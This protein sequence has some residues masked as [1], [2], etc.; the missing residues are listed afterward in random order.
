MKYELSNG[1]NRVYQWDRNITIT[2]TEP[3]NVPQVHF[4]WGGEAAPF[5]VTDQQV[6]IPP[7]LMQLPKNIVFWAYTPDH[8]ID[9]ALIPLETR[10]KPADYVYTPTEIKTW[11]QLD[12]RIKALEEGGGISGVS[13]VNGQTGAVEITAKG[14]GAL[15]KD[16]LQDATNAALAQAKASGEFDGAQGPKGDTGAQ[17]PKG[18]TG[19]QGPQGETGPQGSAGPQGPTGPTGT[20]GAGLDVTGAAVG[21]IVKITAVDDNGVPTAWSPVDMPSGGSG[22]GETWELVAEITTTENVN[23]IRATFDACSAVYI[24]FRWGGVEDDLGDIAIYPNTG[25]TP[26]A[27][28]QRAAAAKVTSSTSQKYGVLCVRMDCRVGSYWYATSWQKARGDGSFGAIDASQTANLEIGLSGTAQYS[29]VSNYYMTT[30]GDT[31]AS[32]VKSITAYGAGM[33]IGTTLKVWG[34]KK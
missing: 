8:T 29:V 3:E 12:E 19:A 5:A 25:D 31:P 6:A 2:I 27:G 14:L 10:P 7:E 32:G 28:E 30:R 16:D 9:M 20:A 22:G 18:D 11:E 33:A 4:K 21:Q 17:G 23:S 24:D 1:E 26:Y 15:T 13:S 34:I